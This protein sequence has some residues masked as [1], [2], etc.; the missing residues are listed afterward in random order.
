VGGVIA[1][2]LEL[3]AASGTPSVATVG[4]PGMGSMA[5]KVAA[6]S[7]FCS[8]L[9]SCLT[10]DVCRDEAREP[11]QRQSNGERHPEGGIASPTLVQPPPTVV[12]PIASSWGLRESKIPRDA[13][14]AASAASAMVTFDLADGS[15]SAS[16]R[17][18]SPEAPDA[19]GPR[20]VP[21]SPPRSDSSD[22]AALNVDPSGGARGAPPATSAIPALAFGTH[23]LT[24]GPAVLSSGTVDALPP[25]AT[26]PAGGKTSAGDGPEK[27]QCAED[28]S[29]NRGGNA[30]RRENGPSGEPVEAVPGSA[31]SSSATTEYERNTPVA[32]RNSGSIAVVRG[33]PPAM[34]R[35]A[36][37]GAEDAPGHTDQEA[38]WNMAAP[39]GAARDAQP[40]APPQPQSPA[41]S[42]DLELPEPAPPP[43]SRDLAW[44]LVDGDSSVDIR[45][46]ERAGEVS[47]TVHTPDGNLA[48]SLRADLPDLVGKLRQS[49]VQAE[50]WRPSAAQSDAGRRSG[51]D[52]SAPQEHSPGNRRDGR[53]RPPLPQPPKNQSRW[54]GEWKSSLDPVQESR[55]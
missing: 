23:W 6:R 36:D 48:D 43:V 8:L 32:Q 1:A 16:C 31:R 11:N 9:D 42:A 12:T 45:V 21:P 27:P 10:D 29:T 41:R 22:D 4:G 37:A 35:P 5:A 54:A 33:A 49:G 3:P 38:S 14:T 34:E 7:G 55:I 50:V 18:V 24:P 15:L 19:S 51:A 30:P 47:V 26:A 40:A 2:S 28:P 44:H 13:G 17:A 39:D 25:S 52:G 20:V 53:E 46:A